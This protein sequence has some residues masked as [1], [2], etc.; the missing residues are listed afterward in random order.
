MVLTDAI[1]VAAERGEVAAI[2]QWLNA[3]GD[4]N[5]RCAITGETL[6]HI[7][8]GDEVFHPDGEER[9]RCDIHVSCLAEQAQILVAEA[10]VRLVASR[11]CEARVASQYLVSLCER[12]ACCFGRD[13]PVFAYCG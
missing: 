5:D 9:G 7:I 2:E 3:G 1:M 10:E 4:A 6:L 13:S 8:A 11:R 12:R